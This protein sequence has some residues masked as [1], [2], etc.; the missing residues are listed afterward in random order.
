MSRRKQRKRDP[1]REKPNRP[2]DL[3][4]DNLPPAA[5]VS[6]LIWRNSKATP[7]H[8][9]VFFAMC[10]H[11]DRYT[12]VFFVS[13]ERIAHMCGYACQASVQKYAAD[14]IKWGHLR[15]LGEKKVWKRH[16]AHRGV[17]TYQII[18]NP[19]QDQDELIAGIPAKDRAADLPV[20]MAEV[21]PVDTVRPKEASRPRYRQGAV[22][23]VRTSVSEVR[24]RDIQVASC[25]FEVIP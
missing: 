22:M 21:E 7:N 12:G 9:D 24:P 4:L 20:D 5:Y 18:F 11:A 13:L 14:L 19:E 6:N 3:N 25:D 23:A 17:M 2:R 15:R 1:R 16:A 10:A 8:R